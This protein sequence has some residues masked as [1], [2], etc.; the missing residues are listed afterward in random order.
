MEMPSPLLFSLARDSHVLVRNNRVF[1]PSDKP[2]R[3]YLIGKDNST[4][5]M[6]ESETSR[7]LEMLYV[8]K[9][10]KLLKRIKDSYIE[11]ILGLQETGLK[12]LEE[13]IRK[14]AVK[15]F[16]LT[17]VQNAYIDSLGGENEFR[18][19]GERAK[20]QRQAYVEILSLAERKRDVPHGPISLPKNVLITGN[21]LYE[22]RNRARSNKPVACSNGKYFFIYSGICSLDEIEERAGKQLEAMILG[23]A[24]A[25]NAELVAPLK[26]IEEFRSA[27]ASGILDKKG[28]EYQNLGFGY[29]N[30]SPVVYL[31]MDKNSDYGVGVYL[32]ESFG[33]VAFDRAAF[34]IKIQP[35]NIINTSRICLA[36]SDFGMLKS[37][38]KDYTE[39]QALIRFLHC[40]RDRVGVYAPANNN[41][42]DNNGG[43][44]GNGN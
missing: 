16:Y 27:I 30:S 21:N 44:D 34:S 33:R 24:E 38:L 32:K 36:H 31:R 26:K 13:Q 37:E 29:C 10:G 43:N 7:G 14:D 18:Q 17:E 19:L 9:F 22:L 8:V 39:G 28:F 40:V 25:E 42:N 35:K 12:K 11:K 41:N 15:L 4:L 2:S 23:I 5:P 20:A 3:T 1:Q 6:E